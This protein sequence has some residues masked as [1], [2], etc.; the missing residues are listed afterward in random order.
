MQVMEYRVCKNTA[1]HREDWWTVERLVKS[2]FLFVF[3]SNRWLVV[4]KYFYSP[5]GVSSFPMIF[6]SEDLAREWVKEDKRVPSHEC[7]PA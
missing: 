5:F 4:K 7:F 6:S 3:R 1:P 2:R